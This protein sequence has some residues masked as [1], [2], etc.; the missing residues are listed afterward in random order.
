M[1]AFSRYEIPNFDVRQNIL[2]LRRLSTGRIPMQRMTARFIEHHSVFAVDP[3]S[4]HVRFEGS[5]FRIVVKILGPVLTVVVAVPFSFPPVNSSLVSCDPDTV[6]RS[7][8]PLELNISPMGCRFIFC[9]GDFM[10]RR[11]RVVAEPSRALSIAFRIAWI[12]DSM[13][14]FDIA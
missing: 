1:I 13:S 8:L 5:T 12:Q 6:R 2:H 3:Q 11:S 4:A 10:V 14:S 7:L 9:G